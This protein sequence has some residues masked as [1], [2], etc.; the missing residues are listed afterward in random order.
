MS[1]KLSTVWDGS[2]WDGSHL[3]ERFERAR[4]PPRLLGRKGLGALFVAPE[5]FFAFF[6]IRD[7]QIRIGFLGGVLEAESPRPLT[8]GDAYPPG[9]RFVGQA[10]AV[11]AATSSALAARK[12][13]R[14]WARCIW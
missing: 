6:V 9:G 11:C 1:H 4:D 13:V 3:S 5:C 8:G 10:A 2:V 12:A 7:G 14:I